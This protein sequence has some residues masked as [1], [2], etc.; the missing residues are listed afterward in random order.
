MIIKIMLN[1]LNK[2]QNKIINLNSNLIICTHQI[3]ILRKMQQCSVMLKE[4]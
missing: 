2:I 1:L 3:N 4:I